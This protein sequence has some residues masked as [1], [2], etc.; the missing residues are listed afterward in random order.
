MAD[1]IDTLK[2]MDDAALM[3]KMGL[4]SQL[5]E[6]KTALD[7]ASKL[8]GKAR[9]YVLDD[10]ERQLEPRIYGDSLKW[11]VEEAKKRA[12]GKTTPCGVC[13]GAVDV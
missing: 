5:E 4:T 11:R 2:A 10:L 8:T 6:F 9:K 3:K 12:S 13:E 7:E 1:A